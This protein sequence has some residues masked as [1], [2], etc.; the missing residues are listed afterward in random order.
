MSDKNALYMEVHSVVSEIAKTEGK[1]LGKQIGPAFIDS[2]TDLVFKQ[3][4]SFG[5]DVEAFSSHGRRAVINMDDV[6]LCARR[7][8]HLHTML[9]GMRDDLADKKTLDRHFKNQ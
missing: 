2:L 1:E 9:S 8:D 7:N 5:L 3:M 4:E 6:M